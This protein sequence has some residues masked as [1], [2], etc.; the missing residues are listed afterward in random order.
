MAWYEAADA[1]GDWPDPIPLVVFPAGGLYREQMFERIERERRR[2]YVAF[3]GSSLLDVLVGVEAGLGITLLPDGA[4][5]GRRVRPCALLGA[6]PAMA[7]S[8][9]AWERTSPVDDLVVQ[10]T[11]IL[12][13][14]RRSPPS[15][16][17]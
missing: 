7:V 10:M 5:V 12:G 6:E 4:T 11:A 2:W 15:V 13:E 17:T 16:P 14:S 3:S 1:G 8:L 9:Y